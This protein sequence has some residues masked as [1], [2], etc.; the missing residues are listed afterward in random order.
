MGT[1]LKVHDELLVMN[2][3]HTEIMIRGL[4][5]PDAWPEPAG[6]VSLVETHISWV[7]LAGDFAYKIKKPVNFGFL[8]FSTLEKRHHFC[9]E[10]LR[11]NRRFAPDLYLE[12]LPVCGSAQRPVVGGEGPTFEYAVKMRRFDQA[13]L[14]S[15]EVEQLGPELMDDLAHRVAEF[16]AQAAICDQADPWGE[17]EAVV[18]PVLDNFIH[19]RNLHQSPTVM[20]RLDVLQAWA[21]QQVQKLS[22]V[23]LARKQEGFVRECHGDLH[24]GNITLIDRKPVLFDGIEFNPALRWIDVMSEIAFLLMDLEE[25]GRP[26]LANRFLNSYLEETGDYTGLKLL[27]FYLMYR[28]MVRAKVTALRIHQSQLP[29]DERSGLEAEFSTYLQQA[30]QYIQPSAPALMITFGTSG[31]GKSYMAR[32]LAEQM[33]AIRVR[34]DV[35]R[36]R[37]AGLQRTARSGSDLAEGI[38]SAQS[39]AATYGRLLELAGEIIAAGFPVIVDATF[40]RRAQRKPFIELA[41][42]LKVPCVIL[43]RQ[44]AETVM[45]GRIRKRLAHG[46]G[47]SEADE[48]VLDQQLLSMEQPDPGEKSLVL[49][50]NS[51]DTFAIE[52]LMDK[53]GS[54]YSSS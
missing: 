50:F 38:Y 29:A 5:D 30:E 31:S 3:E 54:E 22:V 14:L 43:Q 18:R 1:L 13:D 20:Q 42:Q 11:L 52:E 7:F 40:L 8:D 24:L 36:K 45:R 25:K 21:L 26:A 15:N 46:R 53:L 10:E 6:E 17:A 2:S 37:L 39:T 35:E 23:F 49:T 4:M 47:A 28:A 41:A 34:S 48:S 12:V 19:I 44:V 16:H 32:Y 51:T 9:N 27:P 33:P